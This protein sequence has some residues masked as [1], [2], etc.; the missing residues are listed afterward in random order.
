MCLSDLDFSAINGNR[1]N[2]FTLERAFKKCIKA[3]CG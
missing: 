3:F 2:E 1:I